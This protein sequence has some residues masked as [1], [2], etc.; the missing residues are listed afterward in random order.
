[1]IKF[2]IKYFP[3][4]SAKLK[5]HTRKNLKFQ[6]S[7]QEVRFFEQGLKDS[8]EKIAMVKKGNKISFNFKKKLLWIAIISEKL[9]QYCMQFLFFLQENMKKKE[10]TH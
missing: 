1:M 9:N 5:F 10:K 4:E 6:V 8:K 2:P 7:F 3:I